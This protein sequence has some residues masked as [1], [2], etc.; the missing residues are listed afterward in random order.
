[1]QEHKL[2]MNHQTISSWVE[3]DNKKLV[4]QARPTSTRKGWVLVY[5]LC[6]ATLYSAVQS[7][8]SLSSHDVC[9]PIAVKES[10]DIFSTTAEAVKVL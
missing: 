8:C 1:M 10:L 3:S 7:R 9:V 2:L 5:K 6:P 4:S